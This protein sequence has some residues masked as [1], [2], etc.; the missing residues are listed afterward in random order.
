MYKRALILSLSL[1]LLG[2]L[3][4]AVPNY[5]MPKVI[6]SGRFVYV[7]AYDGDQ[8]SPNLLP[9]DRQAIT[10][11]QSEL[12]KWGH[13]TVVYRPKEA[14]VILV[15]QSRPSEDVL[16]AY[17]AKD[18]QEYLWRAMGPNGLQKGEAPLMV[19]FERAVNQVSK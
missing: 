17:D 11:V 7:R 5:V 8:F 6:A 14:D 13:Y 4:M 3:A 16:A 15:V 2:A 10:T 12:Q 9:E 19:Q 1:G 18:P